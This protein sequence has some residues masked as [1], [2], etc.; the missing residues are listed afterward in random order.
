MYK[1]RITS[2]KCAKHSDTKLVA[3]LLYE[4]KSHSEKI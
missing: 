2:C 4:S 1:M 3:I